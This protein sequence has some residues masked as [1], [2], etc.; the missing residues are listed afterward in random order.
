ME[1]RLLAPAGELLS[2]KGKYCTTDGASWNQFWTG[3]TSVRSTDLLH[4]DTH[5][6]PVYL[7]K[8]TIAVAG[9]HSASDVTT[10]SQ[11]EVQVEMKKGKKKEKHRS[12]KK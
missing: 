10:A 6:V 9:Q 8:N 1:M 4:S 2:N 11:T 7:E 3:L 12:L 5:A